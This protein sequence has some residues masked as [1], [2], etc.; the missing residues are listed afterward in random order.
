[1][2]TLGAYH[3]G[4][5]PE[6]IRGA[7]RKGIHAVISTASSMHPEPIWQ[8]YEEEMRILGGKSPSQMFYQFYRPVERQ[9]AIDLIQAVKKCGYK[10]LWITVDAPALGKRTAV[11]A[12]SAEEALAV[13]MQEEG[14]T[15]APNSFM[16]AMAGGDSL[17][18]LS[19]NMSWVDL[20]WVKKEWKGP[21]VLKGIQTA[22]D[23][24]IAFQFGDGGLRNGSD[25][26]KALCLGATA[27]G[28][29]RPFLYALAAFGSQGVERCVDA[30]AGSYVL[31][32]VVARYGHA[33]RLLN[34]M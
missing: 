13:W 21:I 23:A 14:T 20:E 16:P 5:E 6:L 8:S 27:V 4:A 12:L 26:L 33:T 25:V 32:P 1:M 15:E 9:R 28:V 22:Q 17:G 3:S 30:V 19:P 31:G 29:E 34:D 7:V 18:Q 2:G 24:K 10:G 11:R